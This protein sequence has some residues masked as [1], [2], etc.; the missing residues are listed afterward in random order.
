[1]SINFILSSQMSVVGNILT[2]SLSLF[3]HKSEVTKKDTN[4]RSNNNSL[5]M[6][7]YPNILRIE[8]STFPKEN[9]I[10]K[11]KNDTMLGKEE[12]FEEKVIKVQTFTDSVTSFIEYQSTEN[13]NDVANDNI[14]PKIADSTIKLLTITDSTFIN[15]SAS[16]SKTSESNDLTLSEMENTEKIIT[17]RPIF[18]D[19]SILSKSDIDIIR[20][21]LDE[22]EKFLIHVSCCL[23]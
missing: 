15:N 6:I 12:V 20:K 9:E 5:L 1:M 11:C 8:Y 2:T 17:D 13:F 19:S 4:T 23:L 7:E 16:E 14:M 10:E 18:T 3:M 21:R 22:Y